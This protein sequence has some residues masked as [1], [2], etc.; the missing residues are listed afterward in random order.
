[1]YPETRWGCFDEGAS[2][3]SPAQGPIRTG[4]AGYLPCVHITRGKGHLCPTSEEVCPPLSGTLLTLSLGAVLIGPSPAD[5]SRRAWTWRGLRSRGQG[6]G[7]MAASGSWSPSLGLWGG[8]ASPS[9]PS[10]RSQARL[11]VA[12]PA[13]PS[14]CRGAGGGKAWATP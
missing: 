5:F 9:L 13:H 1:M 2:R 14:A 7:S 6:P 3:C 10:E 11:M 12:T 4:P 8:G